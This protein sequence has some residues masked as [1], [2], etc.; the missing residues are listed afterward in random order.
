MMNILSDTN[1]RI[2]FHLRELIKQ[3]NDKKNKIFAPKF[4]YSKKSCTFAPDLKNE[5]WFATKKRKCS[6]KIMP[7]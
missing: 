6:L 5:R 4:L 1:D 3:K 2:F 7:P